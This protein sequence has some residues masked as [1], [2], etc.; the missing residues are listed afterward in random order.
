MSDPSYIRAAHELGD[1]ELDDQLEALSF[2]LEQF[3]ARFEEL[4]EERERRGGLTILL[5]P[6]L[7]GMSAAARDWAGLDAVA[8]VAAS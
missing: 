8:P 3:A 4:L 2:R 6:R 7:T 5:H 1:G